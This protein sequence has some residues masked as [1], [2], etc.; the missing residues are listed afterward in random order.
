MMTHA[1]AMLAKPWRKYVTGDNARDV[2]REKYDMWPVCDAFDMLALVIV[3]RDCN[4]IQRRVQAASMLKTLKRN[5]GHGYA[6]GKTQE[7][8]LVGSDGEAVCADDT[9]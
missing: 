5:G 9:E 2:I 6:H 4:M 7:A 1:E 8:G 3:A